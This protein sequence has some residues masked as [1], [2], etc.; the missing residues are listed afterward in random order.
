MRAIRKGAEPPSLTAHRKTPNCDYDNYADKGGLRHAIVTEQ[1]GLCCY[2]MERI[3]NGPTT[4]KIEHW[5]CQSEYPEEQLIYRNMLGACLGGEGQP[6]RL[7]HCDTRKGEKYLRWNPAEQAHHIESRIRY[8][9]DGTIRS[10][11]EDFDFQLNKVLNLNL[12]ILKNSRKNVIDSVIDW[13]KR[14]KA[15]L[16][17]RVPRTRIERAIISWSVGT[18]ELRPYCQVA[19]W[20]LKQRL[21]SMPK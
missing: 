7:Q 18:G 17:D 8:D 2:C 3:R 11:E 20:W 14:E 15:R 12:R 13:W 6:E 21:M 10:D 5:H 16:H 1:L 4:M 19:V 9:P